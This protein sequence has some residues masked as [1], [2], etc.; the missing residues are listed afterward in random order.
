MAERWISRMSMAEYAD[1][2]TS[3]DAYAARF[4]GPAGEWLLSRQ[5][6]LL[7]NF[8]SDYPGATV[9]DIGGGHAQAVDALW[10]TGA[11]ITVRGSD[12]ICAKRL[13]PWLDKQLI[14]F[15]CGDLLQLPYPDHSFDVVL[16]LRLVPHCEEWRRLIGEMCRVSKAVVILD[17]PCLE[18]FNFFSALFFRRKKQMEGNTRE[19]IN[20]RH[21]E[22]RSA[23]EA[24]G[25]GALSV[26]KQFFWP[27]VIH[28]SLQSPRASAA[29]E[30]GAVFLGLR[31]LLGSPVLI[32]ACK[33]AN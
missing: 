15:H 4:A 29:L 7:K 8:L 1:I 13:Q 5:T 19:W 16:S 17:Y 20:F 9:L 18:S 26:R 2:E 23:F 32:K 6:Y 25:W 21:Q 31:Q 10:Q 28:R 3:S 24:A 14:E 12:E 11:R 22:I 33:G 30:A 27:M